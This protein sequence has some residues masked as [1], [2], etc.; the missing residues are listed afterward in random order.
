[1]IKTISNSLYRHTTGGA[2]SAF[3]ALMLLFALIIVPT[4]QSRVESYSGGI[5]LVDLQFSY[6]P[7]KV[8]SM[9]SSYGEAGRKFYLAFAASGDLIYPVVYSIFFSLI[10]SWLLQR[11]SKPDS[12]LRVLNV[13]PFGALL[14]DWLENANLIAMLS[15]YPSTNENIATLGSLCTMLKWGFGAASVLLLVVGLALAAKNGFR[16]QG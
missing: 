9:I 10:I 16:K 12:G 8:Y 6:T 7:E 1:M 4:I 2:M 15:N 11:G 3:L 13:I 5:S 14:F